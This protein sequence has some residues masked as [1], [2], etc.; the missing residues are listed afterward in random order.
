E[1]E[2][3]KQM[4]AIWADVLNVDVNEIGRDTSFFAMG[5]D[6]ISV[7]KV[8]AACKNAG[9]SISAAAFL[10][11]PVLSRVASAVAAPI[12]TSWPSSSLD[13]ETSRVLTLEWKDMLDLHD[14]SVYP[15]TP[16]Q[17][18]MLYETLNNRSAYVNQISMQLND[19]FDAQ[20][21][22]D[23]FKILVESHDILR[24]TFVTTSS[25]IFQVVRKSIDGLIVPTTTALSINDFL[26]LDLARGFEIGEKYFVRL[27][28]V[29]VS[30]ERFAVMTIHHALYDGWTISMLFND[31]FDIVQGNSIAERPSFT[32]VV[33]FIE[34]QNK[35]D[36]EAYWRSYLAGVVSS[37]LVSAGSKMTGSTDDADTSLSIFST[38]PLSTITSTARQVGVTVAELCKLAWAATL[39]KYTRQDDVVFGQ[40]MANRDIPV[41]DVERILGPLLSTVPCRICFDDK[42]SLSSL[43]RAVQSE[44]GSMM[45]H[46]HASLVDMKRWSGIEGDFLDTL[47]VF[48]NLPE[49]TSPDN[50]SGLK[51]IQPEPSDGIMKEFALEILVEPSTSAI[52]MHM[53]LNPTY[54]TRTQARL[55]L[56]ELDFTLAQLC[57][58]LEMES[59]ASM[60]WALSP[61]QTQMVHSSSFGHHAYLPYELLHHAFEEHALTN[62]AAR[63]VEYEDVWLS[64]GELNA[65][66]SALASELAALGVG[67]GSRVAVIMGR[68]LEFPIGMLAALKVGTAIIPL[69]ASFPANRMSFVLAD[70]KAQAIISTSSNSSKI[71]E[72]ALDIPVIYATSSYLATS[73]VSFEPS[74]KNMATRN[75]EA[76]IV[77]TSG[78]TGKPKGVPVLHVG[79]VNVMFE[80]AHEMGFVKGSRV[81]QFLSLG[82]DGC[83][84]EVWKTLSH[85]G[86]LVFRGDNV[87]E[88]LRKVDVLSCTPTGLGLFGNPAQFPNLKFVV[89][90][91]EAM[92]SSLK[93]LWCPHVT[94]INTYGPSECAIQT[95][96]NILSI[97]EAVTLGTTIGNMNCYILD[98]DQRPVPIGVV[99]EIYLG[100]IGVSPGY[101]NLPDETSYRFVQDHIAGTQDNMFRT[102]RNDTQ[103]KLKGYR[104]ELDEVAEAIMQHPSVTSAA[105]L[106]KD[107]SHLVGYFSP[108]NVN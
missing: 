17:G 87:F 30:N 71:N 56:D 35:D 12:Q 31:L 78:S 38:T 69:D 39:R 70:A 27:T 36:T 48:Q 99:G 98:N 4:A 18:G 97:D 57:D 83:Q 9:L 1:T 77:Y 67:V 104:I 44:R 22:C 29:E 88:T 53:S 62:P 92:P 42:V 82:F 93:D 108:V 95:H 43:L 28:I 7:I 50:M 19:D 66:A 103:V 79:A 85:G 58:G 90:G 61:T 84:E 8:I 11:G 86:T 89:V 63:A 76:F 72:M 59:S 106:V 51:T 101:I 94:L 55:I 25:G 26:E 64:Y 52:T 6:S 96:I 14:Y 74:A 47:F 102:G 45:P 13:A 2:T 16:L 20:K 34:G 73:D 68:C 100:G 41:K 32:T 10:H 21:L 46:S 40:V 24:T 91:G 65:E 107:K 23:A 54:F 15:V 81:M 3:E 33:D 80:R 37:P 49:S 75:D 60:L 105:A 5:G